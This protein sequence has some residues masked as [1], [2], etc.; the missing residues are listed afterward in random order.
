MSVGPTSPTVTA[1]RR[2]LAVHQE[3]TSRSICNHQPN[4]PVTYV[5]SR[6]NSSSGAMMLCSSTAPRDA[7]YRI[8]IAPPNPFSPLSNMTTVER[9]ENRQED[10]HISSSGSSGRERSG[11]NARSS[12]KDLVAQFETGLSTDPALAWISGVRQ[13][14]Q[15][16]IKR[17]K[18]SN[19]AGGSSAAPVW[20][21][22]GPH[23]RFK[24]ELSEIPY[25]CGHGAT[26]DDVQ[27]YAR[28]TPPTLGT[29]SGC[30]GDGDFGTLEVLPGAHDKLDE[31][32][33]LLLLVEQLRRIP[34]TPED[35]LR[36]MN[37]S[38][39]LP[40]TPS[41]SLSLKTLIRD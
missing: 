10:V 24:W 25:V 21:W 13:S 30:G 31:I 27:C 38:G 33:V 1:P 26:T 14:L 4:G 16:F 17:P 37:F 32:V 41:K 20:T 7:V 8:S 28:F 11:S 6:N 5:F 40:K 12:R 9:A 18:S 15:M 23:F 19:K 35:M 2:T 39:V 29:S 22:N 36:A 34:E 3:D